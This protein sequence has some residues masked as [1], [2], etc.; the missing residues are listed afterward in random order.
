VQTKFSIE[1]IVDYRDKTKLPAVATMVKRATARL[2][3]GAQLLSDG[4]QVQVRCYS[5][6]FFT[7]KVEQEAQAKPADAPSDEFLAALKGDK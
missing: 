7:S 6:D 3:A 1:V 5:D 4:Q 2:N